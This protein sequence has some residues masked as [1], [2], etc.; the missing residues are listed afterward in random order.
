MHLIYDVSL[1]YDGMLLRCSGP[2][3]KSTN[4]SEVTTWETTTHLTLD[5]YRQVWF[6]SLA[7]IH[8]LI[9]GSYTFARYSQAPSI[10]ISISQHPTLQDSS[11][12]L[13]LEPLSGPILNMELI[14]LFSQILHRPLNLNSR[15]NF[16]DA[17]WCNR[18]LDSKL[19]LPCFQLHRWGNIH[20]PSKSTPRVSGRTHRAVLSTCVHG[21]LG[22]LFSA[23]VE[24]CP[25]CKSELWVQSWI[26]P[27]IAVG[28]CDGTVTVRLKDSVVWRYEDRAEGGVA[29]FESLMSE[30]DG[31][32]EVFVIL[33]VDHYDNAGYARSGAGLYWDIVFVV[34]V[35]GPRLSWVVRVEWSPDSPVSYQVRDAGKMMMTI[36]HSAQVHLITLQPSVDDTEYECCLTS[37]NHEWGLKL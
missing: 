26:R 24:L 3:S 5:S 20:D 30:W 11:L 19:V 36:P 9:Q 16:V 12:R 22:A 21:G 10:L 7:L 27:S 1:R 17:Q 32:A 13:G 23:E 15:S 25:P 6:S 18:T 31:E 29:C 35:Y 33:F 28:T 2:A 37:P 4:Q 8:H 14:D 34:R